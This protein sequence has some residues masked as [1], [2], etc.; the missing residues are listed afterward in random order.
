MDHDRRGHSIC[1]IILKI[2][3]KGKDPLVGTV[4]MEVCG[5]HRDFGLGL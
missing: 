5:E 3:K 4:S 2:V 1:E